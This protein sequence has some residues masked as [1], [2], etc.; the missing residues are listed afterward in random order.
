MLDVVAP[1]FDTQEVIGVPRV[2][3]VSDAEAAASGEEYELVVGA[4][5]SLD[6]DAFA[7][8]FG[9][10]L[11]AIGRASAEAEGLILRSGPGS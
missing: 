2:D 6:V 8:T 10:P 1:R 4:S 5:M 3:G 9:I 7:A 11:T